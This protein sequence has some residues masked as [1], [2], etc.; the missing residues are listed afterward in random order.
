[1]Q[2]MLL[3]YGLVIIDGSCDVAC[4][5]KSPVIRRLSA[6]TTGALLFT[7]AAQQCVIPTIMHGGALFA[8]IMH[9][10][11]TRLGFTPVVSVD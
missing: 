2:L 11:Q 10:C 5:F 7:R 1:M 4:L 9:G 6:G 3:Y 8:R